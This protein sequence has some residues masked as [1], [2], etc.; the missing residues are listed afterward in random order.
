M[1][2]LI[3]S[4]SNSRVARGSIATVVFVAAAL[5][6]NSSVQSVMAEATSPPGNCFSSS[7]LNQ[8]NVGPAPTSG[9]Q[10][11]IGFGYD[12]PFGNGVGTI[13]VVWNA[14]NSMG[15]LTGKGIENPTHAG[16]N[17]SVWTITNFNSPSTWAWI[18]AT[19][20]W[21]NGGTTITETVGG[22]NLAD[23]PFGC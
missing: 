6:I 4:L 8:Y 1:R 7:S 11:G 21:Q 16:P 23:Y 20:Y 15:G 19:V 10:D 2:H 17:G 9:T 5:L 3:T 22:H 13:S 12:S 18:N 14:Y